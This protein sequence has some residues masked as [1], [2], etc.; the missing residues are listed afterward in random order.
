MRKIK[1]GYE[2]IKRDIFDIEMDQAFK[3]KWLDDNARNALEKYHSKF[4]S[5]KALN[6]GE[7]K[8]Y[9]EIISR[10]LKHLIDV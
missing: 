4:R 2:R 10:I 3:E 8:E 6:T 9:E 7:L 1:S 5:G